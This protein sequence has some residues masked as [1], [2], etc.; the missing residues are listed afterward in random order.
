MFNV[1]SGVQSNVLQGSIGSPL[2]RFGSSVAI[3]DN[4]TMVG[5]PLL[6]YFT[7]NPGAA[8]FFDASSGTELSYQIGSG[9]ERLGS[10]VGVADKYAIAGA[11]S[12]DML[13]TDNGLAYVFQTPSEWIQTTSGNWSQGFN[14]SDGVA[15]NGPGAVAVFSSAILSNSTVTLDVDVTAH[16][17]KF[18]Y[19]VRSYTLAGPAH[20]LTLVAR[21]AEVPTIE[22]VAG[23]HTISTTIEGTSGLT[24][25]GSGT[26][27]LSGA[28]SIPA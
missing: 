2:G 23:V 10:S 11:W 25:T 20:A 22:V 7:T 5:T 19:A 1:L 4:V 18:D 17:L 16:K 13:G 8:F 12:N 9:N 26:L 15:P 27:V 24:K 21:Q 14:W 28:K 6:D 3:H